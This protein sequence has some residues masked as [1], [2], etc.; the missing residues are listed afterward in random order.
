[1]CIANVRFLRLLIRWSEVRILAAMSD[2]D[3]ES[4]DRMTDNDLI[5]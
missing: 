2:Y 1:M 3:H 4:T 5:Q